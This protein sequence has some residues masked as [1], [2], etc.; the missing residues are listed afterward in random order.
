M[1]HGIA[2][3]THAKEIYK[4]IMK[5]RH[6]SCKFQDPGMTIMAENPFISVSPDLEIECDC[7]GKGLV[8]IKCPASLIEHVPTPANYQHFEQKLIHYP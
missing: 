7:H 8:Q 2:N 1:K 4:S 3:E 6:K 5:H